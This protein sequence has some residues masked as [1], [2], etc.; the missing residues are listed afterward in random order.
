M[1]VVD[2]YGRLAA[3][4]PSP[5]VELNRA[6]ALSMAAG[7]AAG[8]DLVDQLV[9]SGTLDGY[10]LLHGVRGDLL[11]K[12]G[13]SAEA[14]DAFTLAASLTLNT[15]ERE[16]LLARAASSGVGATDVSGSAA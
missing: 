13:R 7:P 9:E 11:D 10:H 3:V 16:L 5:I 4:A 15:S 6:V 12:L 14:A 8:L 2:L 1:T